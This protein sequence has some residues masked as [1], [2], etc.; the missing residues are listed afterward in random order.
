MPVDLSQLSRSSVRS[1]TV[2]SQLLPT[3]RFDPFAEGEPSPLLK[4]IRPAVDVETAVGT[5]TLAPY[6]EPEADYSWLTLG[7][8]AVSLGAVGWLAWHGLRSLLRRRRSG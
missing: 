6:G 7:L 1:V 4:W 5:A 2:R 3:Y 8:A